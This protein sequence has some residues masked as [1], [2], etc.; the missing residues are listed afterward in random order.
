MTGRPTDAPL[1]DPSVVDAL[2]ARIIAGD[3]IK[4]ICASNGMPSRSAVYERMAV[5]LA[6]RTRIAGAREAQQDAHIDDT[7]DMADAATIEDHQVVKLRIW[8]RQWRASKLAPKK[9][10]DTLN[11][12]QTVEHRFVARIPEPSATPVDWLKDHGP[13]QIDGMAIKKGVDG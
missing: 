10:G 13:K 1:D 6:F 7:V 5:D 11:V 8:A 9:Y 2:C 3:G 12:E 4:A